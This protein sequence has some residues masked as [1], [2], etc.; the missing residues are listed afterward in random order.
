MR[1]HRKLLVLLSA[2]GALLSSSAVSGAGNQTYAAGTAT[3]GAFASASAATGVP[4]AVLQSLCY[5]EGRL[6]NHGGTASIDGGYGCMHL[7]QNRQAD[8]L[9]QAARDLGVGVPQLR[10]DMATNI[11]GGAAVLRDEAL[12]LSPSHTLPTTLAGWYGAVAAYSH[13]STRSTALMYADAVYQLV[14]SGFSAPTDRG[15]TISLAPRAV[16][17]DRTTAS[18]VRAAGTLP[19][20][21]AV[22]AN[23]DYAPAVDCIVPTSYDCN[24]LPAI[25]PCT[26]AGANR[27]TDFDIKQIV[28]H[29]VEGSAQDAISVFQDI[30]SGVSVQYIVGGDGTVYQTLHEHDVPFGAG[31]RW[32]NNHSINIEHGGFDATGFLWYNATE[33]LASAKLVA[34]LIG[35]YGIPLDHDHI[36]SHG[37]IPGPFLA[38]T[39]NHV[40]PGPY[41]LWDYYLGLV[42]QQ[43]E[44]QK[45]PAGATGLHANVITLHPS[46]DR[47]PLGRNGTETAANFN[48]FYVY[49]G[50]STASGL[51]PQIVGSSDVTDESAN[52][53]PDTSFPVLARVRDP[54]GTGDTMFQIAYGEFDQ[55]Q[56]SPSS[57]FQTSHLAWLAVPPGAAD[58][59]PG[60]A[61]LLTGA[62][63]GPASVFGRPATNELY[64]IGAAATGSV[65]VS[66][67]SVLEDGTTNLW[68]EI[69][70]NHRQAWVPA[71]EVTILPPVGG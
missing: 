21:C 7:V 18:A 20:G 24:P 71:A 59:G 5:M 64:H 11:R 61:V 41:W 37:T 36:V 63:G 13:A 68:Y 34:H 38:A 1:N 39:P 16:T 65:F 60:T 62:N 35:K 40:D 33:Y 19:A 23:V 43:A 58:E 31:N 2:A 3:S 48:F 69:N 30:N 15:E 25:A 32:Y 9:D 4:V 29:D 28:I 22:D 12:A 45:A 27:P 26:Y 8:T 6:S 17:P 51:V 14:N 56:A 49:Q 67:Y 57:L 66:A 10:T 53:E 55:A 50:P 54:A 47:R 46:T 70:F 42:G 52:V 44:A